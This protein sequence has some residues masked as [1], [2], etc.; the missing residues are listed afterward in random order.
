MTEPLIYTAYPSGPTGEWTVWDH[1]RDQAVTT[2]EPEAAAVQ[3]ADELEQ[4][5]RAQ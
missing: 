1:L 3:L 2:G 5:Y 4:A